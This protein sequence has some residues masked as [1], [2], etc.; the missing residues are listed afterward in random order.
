MA[1][2]TTDVRT[3]PDM[4]VCKMSIWKVQF[5]EESPHHQDLKLFSYSE[6]FTITLKTP[7]KIQKLLVYSPNVCEPHDFPCVLVVYEISFNIH[8]VNY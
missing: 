5:E 3:Q 6:T 1:I 2:Y 8:L 7:F 4:C